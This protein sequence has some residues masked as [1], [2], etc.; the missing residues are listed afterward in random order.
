MKRNMRL[1]LV[2]FYIDLINRQ[3]IDG[4]F[5]IAGVDL[6]EKSPEIYMYKYP[7]QENF[8]VKLF[9]NCKERII[10]YFDFF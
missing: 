6:E 3:Y 10:R 5:S 1:R 2:D 7:V 8:H 4:S 9:V